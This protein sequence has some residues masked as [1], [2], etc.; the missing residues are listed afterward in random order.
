MP[1]ALASTLAPGATA[2]LRPIPVDADAPTGAV[3]DDPL[4]LERY[5]RWIAQPDGTRLGE[6]A[7]QL[8]GMHCAACAGI[9]EAALLRVDG[10][11]EARIGSAAQRATV[12]WDPLRTQASALIDAVR[13]AG[14]DAVPDAAA[15][16]RTLRRTE[17]RLA[18]WR[19]FVAWFCMMQV[20]MMATPSY[21][22]PPGDLAPDLSQLLNW[23]QW[24]LTL[25]VML[26]SAAPFFS[27]AWHGLRQRRIG[28]DMPVAMGVLIMFVAGTISTFEPE[29][30]LGAEVYF[31]SLTMFVA[32]L[33]G[34]RWFEMRA[35]HRAAEALETQLAALP[36]TAQRLRDDGSEETVSV[37]RLQ[38]GDR[39]RVPLGEAF[40][41]DGMLEQ[42][43]TE[44][45][46]ALLTGESLPVPKPPGAALVAGSIN[47]GAPVLMRVERAGADTRFEAIV[48]MMRSAMSQRPAAARLADRWAPPFLIAVLLLAAGAAAVWS[49]IDPSRAVWVAVAVLIVTCPCA[50]SLAAP[51]TLVAATRALSRRGVMLQRLDAIE[52]LARSQHFFFDKTGTLTEDRPV[53]AALRPTPAALA[54]GWDEAALRRQAAALARWSTHP[55]SE[56]IAMADEEGARDA[57]PSTGAAQGGLTVSPS[58][59]AGASTL[60]SPD[61]AVWHH[62]SETPGQGLAAT[63]VS[64]VGWRL[65]S[66]EFAGVILDAADA[67]AGA[68]VR[69]AGHAS[70]AGQAP[71]GAASPARVWLARD[72]VPLAA[73]HF[74]EHLRTDAQ[75]A[76]DALKSEGVRLTLLSG[77][78]PGRATA[79]AARLGL[80][81]V[82]G[83]ASPEDKLAA[84]TAAQAPDAQ[85]R[86]R[87]VA[88]VGD[89]LNDAP[90]LARADVSLAMGQGAL[91]ARSQADAVIVSNRLGDLVAARRTAQRALTIVRQNMIWS[92]TYNATCIPL[93]LIGW[94]PPWAAG[95]GMALSSVAVVLNATRAAR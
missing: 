7:L 36:E 54:A 8:S 49:V 92:A 25:P 64:G 73:L 76:V 53:L 51:T 74:E 90:V 40:P 20:M 50:L 16:A 57:T 86:R 32:F 4:E 95:L 35:R 3:L 11:A 46:E 69:A 5:T 24:L 91:V 94:M 84:V 45:D 37:R 38:P 26:F 59:A 22:A 65:G 14:Y 70:G 44:A 15:P 77:D 81:A 89:G 85:G 42:G 72:G 6:S 60:P 79:L 88:M 62:V 67:G 66:P 68:T 83:G 87:P 2:A 71:S 82:H 80:D 30:L 78:E 13:R 9:I 10:V 33:L 21:V 19:L 18:L 56:A 61:A 12:R 39:V 43:R 48:A 28:M 34:G 63:D 75:A 41:A 1:P 17:S 23:G 29:G 47:R 93:A 27:G 58:A 55:L 31:D 52:P